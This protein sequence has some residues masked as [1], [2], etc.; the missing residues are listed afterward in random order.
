MAVS[1]AEDSILH[2]LNMIETQVRNVIQRL[3]RL[4]SLLAVHRGPG[5]L[6]VLKKWKNIRRL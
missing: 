3:T 5:E 4:K 1:H 2:G 6:G